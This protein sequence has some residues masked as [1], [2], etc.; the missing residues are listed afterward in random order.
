MKLSY[1]N[2]EVIMLKN[3][4]TLILLIALSFFSGC[5]GIKESQQEQALTNLIYENTTL[6]EQVKSLTNENT[7]AKTEM[8]KYA[9][10]SKSYET[11]LSK[12]IIHRKTAEDKAAALEENNRKEILVPK[13]ST[14]SPLITHAKLPQKPKQPVIDENKIYSDIVN[15]LEKGTVVFHY[16]DEIKQGSLEIAE[17]RLTFKISNDIM[18]GFYSANGKSEIFTTPLSSVVKV[19]LEGDGFE[20]FP[21]DPIENIIPETQFQKWVWQ[22]RPIKSGNLIL[23]LVIESILKSNASTEK[24]FKKTELRSVNVKVNPWWVSAQFIGKNW[25]Y[26]IST[27]VGSGIIGWGYKNFFMKKKR[28][29]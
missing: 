4:L 23:T 1:I 20:I 8:K 14:E 3:I 25:Q 19:H 15:S 2:E 12:E 22:V 29:K 5:G 9:D 26:I 16:P 18:T 27:I 10:I 24:S 17:A 6:Q 13:N 28:K 21:K 11:Q 7:Q